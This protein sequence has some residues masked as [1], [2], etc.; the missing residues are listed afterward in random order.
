M[1]ARDGRHHGLA[2]LRAQQPRWIL[3]VAVLASRPGVVGLAAGKVTPRRRL[4]LGLF[5][6]YL[7]GPL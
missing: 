3:V 4:P 5:V 2:P 1:A 6:E 7:V